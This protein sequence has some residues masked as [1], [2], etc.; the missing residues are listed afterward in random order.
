MGKFAKEFTKGIIVT[1]DVV[2]YVLFTLFFL[3][4]A[5]TALQSRTWRSK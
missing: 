2:Y 3:F 1:H 4:L 5:L